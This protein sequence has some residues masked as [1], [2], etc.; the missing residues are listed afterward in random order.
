[1]SIGENI[2]KFRNQLPSN[3]SVIAISKTKPIGDILEAYNEGHRIFGENKVQDL[4][5]KQALLP[6]DIYWHFV[7]HLQ[8]NKVKYLAPFISLIH[9]IDSMKLLQVVNKEAVKN[10]RVIP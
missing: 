6:D 8:S 1:M 9:S 5:E 10:E 3:V 4:I 7:G 2:R